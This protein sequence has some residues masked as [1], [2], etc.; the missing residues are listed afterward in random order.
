MQIAALL[1]K[2]SSGIGQI[3][4]SDSVGGVQRK[5][6]RGAVKGG[7]KESLQ[8]RRRSHGRENVFRRSDQNESP[9]KTKKDWPGK[10][11]KP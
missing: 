3:L 7:G 4:D 10:Y 6:K 5:A 8:F 1:G 9:T 2:G 11:F